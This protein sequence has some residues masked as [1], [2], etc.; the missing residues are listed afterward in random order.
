MQQSLAFLQWKMDHGMLQ[1]NKTEVM[2]YA[3]EAH[4]L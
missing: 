2:I 3:I 1:H 4:W